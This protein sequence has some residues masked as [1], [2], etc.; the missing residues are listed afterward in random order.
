MSLNFLPIS[1]SILLWSF[2][3]IT[4]SLTILLYLR[5]IGDERKIILTLLVIRSIT[6]F[7]ILII[8]LGITIS[9]LTSHVEKK[10][11]IVIVDKSPSM[12]Y[13]SV[14]SSNNKTRIELATDV[15]KDISEESKRYGIETIFIGSDGSLINI[16]SI[17]KE[18]IITNSKQ[19]KP[20]YSDLFEIV[21]GYYMRELA[22]IFITDCGLSQKDFDYINKFPDD[23]YIL[24]VGES[25][26]SDITLI[27]FL[28]P[29]PTLS[30]IEQI[31]KVYGVYYGN[32]PASFSIRL[33]QGND[34]LSEVPKRMSSGGFFEVSIPFRAKGS[35]EVFSTQV[36]YDRDENTDNNSLTFGTNVIPRKMRV[37]I[38]S[39]S[40]SPDY[41]LIKRALERD[42]ALDISTFCQTP[43]G[44]LVRE[45]TT[46]DI[47]SM[48]D[49]L[50]EYDTIVYIGNPSISDN[51][52]NKVDSL[53][54]EDGVGNVFFTHNNEEIDLPSSPLS[55][56]GSVG[57][58]KLRCSTDN[59]SN[60]YFFSDIKSIE[61][62][63]VNGFKKTMLKKWAYGFLYDNGGSVCLAGGRYSSGISYAISFWGLWR[64]PFEIRGEKVESFISSLVRMSAYSHLQKRPDIEMSKK[65]LFVGEDIEFAV[66]EMKGT[67]LRYSIYR[68][69]EDGEEVISGGEMEVNDSK[70]RTTFMPKEPGIYR[71]EV[72]YG[73]R[74][75]SRYFI[76]NRDLDVDYGSKVN[77]LSSLLDR[78]RIIYERDISSFMSKFKEGSVFTEK[79]TNTTSLTTSPYIYILIILLLLSEWYI[80]RRHGL[81]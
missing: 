57:N 74:S 18:G 68:I 56:G 76:C 6:I 9:F 48:V 77:I 7:L 50:S 21:S 72:S 59:E 42:E 73:G 37:L 65:E 1:P 19:M 53:C 49:L 23:L 46:V 64:L 45:E 47:V 55:M 41:A 13:K 16:E 78:E 69:F 54:R 67:P 17:S 43:T 28:L 5:K 51:L 35:V 14:S 71:I 81:P 33:Y 31:A 12:N 3:A 30:Y 11:L 32:E 22:F 34:L 20:L 62:L 10:P 63:S 40:P 60:P 52:Y 44:D 27:G 25:P 58:I 75:N 15:I 70:Y 61:G 4:I 8:L 39:S 36:I 80:R 29:D 2:F 38:V 26:K 66:S 24:P 79:I